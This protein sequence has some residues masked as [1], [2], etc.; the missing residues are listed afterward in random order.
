MIL[1]PK[2][3]VTFAGRLKRGDRMKFPDEVRWKRVNGIEVSIP[4]NVHS[5][6]YLQCTLPM[7]KL[8]HY[9]ILRADCPV[10]VHHGKIFMER[11]ES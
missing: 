1:G 10:R 11:H 9:Y 8:S 4:G 5:V 2:G 6:M 7:M 3:Q